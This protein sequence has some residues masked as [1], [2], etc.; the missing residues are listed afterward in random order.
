MRH[1]SF[2]LVSKS[3]KQCP[4]PSGHIHVPSL[5]IGSE[6]QCFCPGVRNW[7]HMNQMEKLLFHSKMLDLG[8]I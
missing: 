7:S 2:H 1:V 4:F 3:T 8:Y 5:P 6:L